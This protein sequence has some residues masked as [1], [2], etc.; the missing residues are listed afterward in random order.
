M[1]KQTM[2]KKMI[3]ISSDAHMASHKLKKA[4][5]PVI[6]GLDVTPNSEQHQTQ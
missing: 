6:L 4:I 3:L 1:A 2:S 5:H